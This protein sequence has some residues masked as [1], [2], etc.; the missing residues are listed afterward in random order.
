MPHIT[1][2]YSDNLDGKVDLK[3]LCAEVLKAALGT[4]IFETGAVR[5]RA[6]RCEAYAI[7]D[8]APDNGFIDM[9]LRLAK[10]RDLETRKRVGEA[11]WAAADAF[12]AGLY[13]GRHFALSFEVREIDP[14]LSWKHNS[15]HDRLRKG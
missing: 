1:L 9:S 8:N 5:V 15:I 4:G 11:I 13:P 7:A 3:G 10:G 2:E 6:M 12:L 14:A